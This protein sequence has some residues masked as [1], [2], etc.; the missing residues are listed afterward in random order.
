MKTKFLLISSLLVLFS[1]NVHAREIAITVKGMV[2]A[3]C[4]QG[5]EKKFK[6]LKEV[7]SVGVSLEKKIVKVTTKADQDIPDQK[8]NEILKD[9]GYNV[10]KIQRD[11]KT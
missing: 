4:A 9:S 3:F 7:E 8:I 10:E 11:G 6:A 1:A 5:I 2:C